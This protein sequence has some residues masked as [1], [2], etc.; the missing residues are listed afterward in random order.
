MLSGLLDRE[1]PSRNPPYMDDPLD[2]IH[3]WED[4][5]WYPPEPQDIEHSLDPDC[6][7]KARRDD[8]AT[9]T[10]TPFSSSPIIPLPDLPILPDIQ[11]APP[12]GTKTKRS[13]DPPAKA[14]DEIFNAAKVVWNVDTVSLKDTVSLQPSPKQWTV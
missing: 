8:I 11:L 14:L 12:T 13:N 9:T 4:D 1:K 3:V 10:T 7:E 5:L 2:P 6:H